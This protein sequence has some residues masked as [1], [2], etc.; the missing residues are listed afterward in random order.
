MKSKKEDAAKD[1]FM[2]NTKSD[3]LVFT[4]RGIM[5]KF[6]CIKIPETSRNASGT[7]IINLLPIDKDDKIATVLRVFSF[8]DESLDLVFCSTKGVGEKNRTD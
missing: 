4:T 7:P 3:L 1:I 6:R 2:A 5:Y 8:D